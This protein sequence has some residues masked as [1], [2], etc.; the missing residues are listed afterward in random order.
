MVILSNLGN[1][2]KSDINEQEEAFTATPN[3]KVAAR[4]INE[5]IQGI[6]GKVSGVQGADDA[7]RKHEEEKEKK[8][9]QTVL[10]LTSEQI[11]QAYA[12]LD[13]SIE[14]MKKHFEEIEVKLTTLRS[15]SQNVLDH[16]SNEIA[17]ANETLL[18]QKEELEILEQDLE[19]T[20]DREYIQILIDQKRAE[21]ENTEAVIRLYN[22]LRDTTQENLTIAT[23]EY[24]QANSDLQKLIEQRDLAVS[25]GAP[26]QYLEKLQRQIEQTEIRIQNASATITDIENRAISSDKTIKLAV[27]ELHTESVSC[28]SLEGEMNKT[29]ATIERTA[30]IKSL[31]NGESSIDEAISRLE[32]ISDTQSQWASSE[33][34]DLLTPETD[35]AAYDKAY[36]IALARIEEA[37]ITNTPLP[38]DAYDAMIESGINVN[39]I[40]YMMLSHNVQLESHNNNIYAAGVPMGSV[41]DEYPQY[42]EPNASYMTPIDNRTQNVASLTANAFGKS[43]IIEDQPIIAEDQQPNTKPDV[44]ND[45]NYNITVNTG[46]IG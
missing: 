29:R 37:K 12:Q 41:L 39:D 30:I 36:N 34:L 21:I 44:K 25:S 14:E 32:N 33:V 10:S 22:G 13:K 35:P 23:Q 46:V 15:R 26:E 27:T 8:R 9:N 24:E 19:T 38:K 3:N 40:E 1:S 43:H 11:A 5:A 6:E 42:A 31:V 20:H 4:Q 18:R 17:L 7:H 28:T 16:L 45:P 2:N